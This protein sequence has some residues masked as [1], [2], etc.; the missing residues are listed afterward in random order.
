MPNSS[1]SVSS[2]HHSQ[3]PGGSTS[4]SVVPAGR[5]VAGTSRPVLASHEWTCG[6]PPTVATTQARSGASRAQSGTSTS[7]ARKRCSHTGGGHPATVRAPRVRRRPR[8]DNLDMRPSVG[9]RRAPGTLPEELWARGVD[10]SG[11]PSTGEGMATT[12]VTASTIEQTITDND[13]VLIDF[14]ADWCGPCKSFAPVYE[15]ASEK[16][17]DVVF[18]KVDT[19]AEQELAA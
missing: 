9:R 7:P 13:I 10:L 16:H 3:F 15:K 11:H 8:R 18:A 2:N 5:S 6:R 1:P 12:D 4:A 14:W 17:T 19:E